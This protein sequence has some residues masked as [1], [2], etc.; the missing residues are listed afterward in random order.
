[1]GR[2]RVIT[3]PITGEHLTWLPT[4]EQTGGELVKAEIRVHGAGRGARV[5]HAHPSAQERFT[6]IRGRMAIECD[7]ELTVLAGG[8]SLAVEPGVEHAWWN[9]RA[10]ELCVHVEVSPPGRYQE[11]TE[12]GFSWAREGRTDACGD[13]GLLLGATFLDAFGSDI[14]FTTAPR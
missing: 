6:V 14:S 8:E 9:A 1:M 10:G 5:P 3:N 7:G 13:P 12:L 2:G 4:G 11:L